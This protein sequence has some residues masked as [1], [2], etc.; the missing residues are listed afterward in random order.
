MDELL[1]KFDKWFEVTKR[2]KNATD[3]NDIIMKLHKQYR[4]W[5][6]RDIAISYRTELSKL[7]K[8]RGIEWKYVSDADLLIPGIRRKVPSFPDFY[9]YVEITRNP[10]DTL[11]E[12]TLK[13]LFCSPRDDIT[14]K[15]WNYFDFQVFCEAKIGKAVAGKFVGI[16][17]RD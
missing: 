9:K 17:L 15:G 2:E 6:R 10:E 7:L 16:K 11:H 8:H 4:S 5:I 13:K 1:V 14:P 12:S 3:C